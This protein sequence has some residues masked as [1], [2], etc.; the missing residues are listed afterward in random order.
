MHVHA[1]GGRLDGP[2]RATV[3]DNEHLVVRVRGDDEGDWK[4]M[5][6]RDFARQ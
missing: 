4:D 1:R 3:G 5:W 2:D 6:T